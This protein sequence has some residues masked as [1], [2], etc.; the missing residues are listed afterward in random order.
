LI[1]IN[2][3]PGDLLATH[4]TG[5][6]SFLIRLGAALRDR[7]NLVN[8]IAVVHHVDAQGVTWCIEGRPGG[9]GWR[10]ASDYLS[11]R[12]TF[13]NGSQPK[14]DAQRD[15]VCKG[16]VA[17]LGTPYDWEA[18]AQDAAGAFGL[19][20]VWQLRWGKAGTVPGHVVCSSL[21]AYLYASA[22]LDCPAGDREVTPGDWLALWLERGWQ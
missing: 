19:D 4:S 16:A 11:N 9:V 5:T 12:H 1:N 8:H 15:E 14:T 21:A 7:P 20:D 10:D 22:G 3:K 2:V 17:L 6:G 13:G 18:I